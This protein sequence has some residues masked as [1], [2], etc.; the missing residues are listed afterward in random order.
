MATPGSPF[1]SILVPY[2]GSEPARSAL[3]HAL[4]LM[5]PGATLTV[6]TVVDETPLLTESATSMVAYD[7]TAIFNALDEQGNVE[8]ADAV[9]R[10][11]QRQITPK[12]E[13]VHDT[14]VEGILASAKTYACDLIVMGTHGR[15]G[16]A[17]L[18]LGSTTGGVLGASDVPVLV[19]R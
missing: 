9:T 10:C 17:R 8:L 1:T 13:L 19:V 12:T 4:D 2:D 11:A 15:T 6:V 7:P 5:H 14:P 3:S 16:L 18:F